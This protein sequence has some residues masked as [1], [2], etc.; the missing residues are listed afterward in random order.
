[1]MVFIEEFHFLGGNEFSYLG[2]FGVINNVTLRVTLK[3][4]A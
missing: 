2:D 4:L 3:I 1:M